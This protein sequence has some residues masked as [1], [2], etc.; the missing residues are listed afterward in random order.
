[1]AAPARVAVPGS[2]RLHMGLSAPMRDGG[3]PI[4]AT[5]R[6]ANTSLNAIEAQLRIR[7]SRQVSAFGAQYR[8]TCKLI[9]A[10]DCLGP[11]LPTAPSAPRQRSGT[12]DLVAGEVPDS[13]PIVPDELTPSQNPR[14]AIPSRDGRSP[15]RGSHLS[16]RGQVQVRGFLQLFSACQT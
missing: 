6:D 14:L 3:H 9:G 5:V 8:I 13:R 2:L 16:H 11:V 4:W 15:A 7:V 1:M 12:W 10:G